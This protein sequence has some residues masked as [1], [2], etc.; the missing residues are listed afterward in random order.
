MRAV[1][2]SALDVPPEI[3]VFEAS[4]AT[5]FL[6]HWN[7]IS[8]PCWLGITVPKTMSAVSPSFLD[9]GFGATAEPEGAL[10]GVAES[11][12]MLSGAMMSTVAPR[13]SS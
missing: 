4:S 10:L 1:I 11:S 3:R 2:C 8:I 5:P 6:R 12:S 7:L 13:L 9:R